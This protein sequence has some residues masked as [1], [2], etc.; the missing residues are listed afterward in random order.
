MRS[1]RKTQS[2]RAQRA[3]EPTA[4]LWHE[5]FGVLR[6]MMLAAF[7]MAAAQ[8]KGST[9]RES[10][11]QSLRCKP[12]AGG[13]SVRREVVRLWRFRRRRE[14]HKHFEEGLF[15]EFS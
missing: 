7:R 14:Y 11:T 3:R 6:P 13:L 12:K 4:Q 15:R 5:L 10:P 8:T 9:K 2:S 1:A